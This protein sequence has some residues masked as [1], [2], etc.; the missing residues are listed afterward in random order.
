MLDARPLVRHGTFLAKVEDTLDDVCHFFQAR[1]SPRAWLRSTRRSNLL[2]E[3]SNAS[4][5]LGARRYRVC[6]P[7]A[8]GSC[9]PAITIFR[10]Q[11][12]GHVNPI[13]RQPR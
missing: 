6:S 11:I 13:F 10:A 12:Y 4:V 9:R 5:V 1:A 2:L 3:R 7:V 8:G